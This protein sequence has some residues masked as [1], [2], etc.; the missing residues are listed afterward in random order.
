VTRV[1]SRSGEFRICVFFTAQIAGGLLG[2]D[3]GWLIFYRIGR[4]LLTGCE[5]GFFAISAIRDF[6]ANFWSEVIA[7]RL[8]LCLWC[9]RIFF[10]RLWSAAGPA[11]GLGPYLV[12]SCVGELGFTGG[13]DGV[14]DQY[15]R[16]I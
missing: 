4:R 9:S 1:A 6:P 11:E 14:R 12:G 15:A 3:A 16:E 13:P 2:D 5:D 8:L 10:S 7:T